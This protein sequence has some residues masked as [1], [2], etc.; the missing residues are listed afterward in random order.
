[1]SFDLERLLSLQRPCGP[2]AAFAPLGERPNSVSCIALFTMSVGIFAVSLARSDR[3]AHR[4][5]N[6]PIGSSGGLSRRRL[7]A[8]CRSLPR[9]PVNRTAKLGGAYRDRT[10][11]LMLAKHALS[12]LS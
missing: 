6:L 10:D 9:H 1:V 7:A 11:D 4:A 2:C 12:Q 3:K 5:M 8:A